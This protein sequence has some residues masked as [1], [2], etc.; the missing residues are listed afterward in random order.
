MDELRTSLRACA[1]LRPQTALEHFLDFFGI[2]VVK[3]NIGADQAADDAGICI[4]IA[5]KFDALAHREIEELANW[6]VLGP[7][8]AVKSQD[9][10]ILDEAHIL[11]ADVVDFAT[12]EVHRI[13]SHIAGAFCKLLGLRKPMGY[14]LTKAVAMSDLLGGLESKL[15][16]VLR[17]GVFE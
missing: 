1:A 17:R 15:C 2:D 4:G 14:F 5:L 16:S 8:E 9:E 3:A 13:C 7:H 12:E 6:Q 10:G 11:G